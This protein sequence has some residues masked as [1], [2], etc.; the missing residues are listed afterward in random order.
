MNGPDSLPLLED[1]LKELA[2]ARQLQ[3]ALLPQSDRNFPFVHVCC[4]N[5]PCHEVG[6]DYCDYFNLRGGRFCFALGDASG[7]GIPA[8]LLASQVQG[9]L[10]VQPFLDIPLPA[11]VSDLNRTLT[12]R[13]VKNRFVTSFFGILDV[14]GNCDYVNAGHNPPL[15]VHQ[16]G[17]IQELIGGGTVLGLFPDAPYERNTI[18][19]QPNDHL[20]MFTDGVVEALNTADEEFGRDRLCALLCARAGSS[21]SELLACL[22]EAVASFAANT[23][24]RDD[25]TLMILG[26]REPKAPAAVRSSRSMSAA[27]LPP[28]FLDQSPGINP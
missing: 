3:Q 22:V 15:L 1:L 9:M 2:V 8:A 4:Q 7:K 23:P 18:R 19:L 25:I 20:V 6:G 10:S 21:A 24:Q 13:G 5:F 12:I 26:F 11:I 17:S 28:P 16:D 27:V 14:E